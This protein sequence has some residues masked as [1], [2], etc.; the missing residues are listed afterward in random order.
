MSR[1]MKEGEKNLAIDEEAVS[2]RHKILVALQQQIF[3]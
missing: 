3:K 1:N 2:Q